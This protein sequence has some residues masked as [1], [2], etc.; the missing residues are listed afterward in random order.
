MVSCKIIQRTESSEDWW[1][2]SQ[3]SVELGGDAVLNY[4]CWLVML[5]HSV[6]PHQ[7]LTLQF[8]KKAK[9]IF[10]LPIPRLALWHTLASGCGENRSIPV[11]HLGLKSLPCIR[12]LGTFCTDRHGE[13][14]LYY[15]HT[16]HSKVDW[17]IPI[18]AQRWEQVSPRPAAHS[19]WLTAA[20]CRWVKTCVQD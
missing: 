11:P 7:C 18:G 14:L 8:F 1:H 19:S 16:G 2:W 13:S 9:C 6:S 4:I 20:D 12:V 3:L 17:F 10:S 15:H 5:I